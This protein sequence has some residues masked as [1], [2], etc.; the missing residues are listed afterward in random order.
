[1]MQQSY[2]LI[3]S[4]NEIMQLEGIKG[5]KGKYPEWFILSCI[6]E[7]LA[8]VRQGIS[9]GEENLSNFKKNPS[10]LMPRI[11]L[12]V[13]SKRDHKL[14]KVINASGTIIH[15]NLGRVPLPIE[16]AGNICEI[17]SSFSNI[18]YDMEKGKRGS[19]YQHCAEMIKTIL[20]CEDAL[21]VNNNA[22]ALLLALSTF[23][24]KKEVLISR[25]EI[26]EI[27]GGFRVN[28]ILRASGA[29]LVEIGTTNK[30]RLSDYENAITEKTSAILKVHRSNFKIVGFQE[31]TGLV[32]IAKLGKKHG[33]T[34]IFDAGSGLIVDLKKYGL[35]DEP[36]VQDAIKSGVDI[37]TFSGD[38]LLGG[39][40][41]GIL[42]ARSKMINQMKKNP[43]LR[44]LRV[45]KMTLSG[46]EATL[47][48]YIDG[49]YEKRIPVISMITKPVSELE[50]LAN[51][52]A[53]LLKKNDIHQKYSINVK[54]SVSCI[55]GGA[56]PEFHLDTRVV[57]IKGPL[58]A[59]KMERK[60]RQSSTPVIARI[61]KGELLL[62]L[63]T[64]LK[65]EIKT[66]G[67]VF[68]EIFKETI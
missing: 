61:E 24:S 5:L 41:A 28:D 64:I 66:V 62:D 32:D 19:R 38:K 51:E 27:G 63:R 17:S 22:A 47:A 29:R 30:T 43:L 2:R 46:L 31:S 20:E 11:S 42:V 25:G 9:S 15:T 4:V 37:V 49:D 52:L 57:S 8:E 18:E 53:V 26:V 56:C 10:N 12:K 36:L 34:T 65:E 16:A 33:L 13:M 60:L 58:R 67:V 44:A 45:C 59:A 21:V 3:P 54:S 23:A 35:K 7:V 14:I 39:P 40:Q 48:S 6:R 68:K 1:M 50:S 55:G